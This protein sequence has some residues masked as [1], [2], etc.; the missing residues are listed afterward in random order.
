MSD[1]NSEV[2]YCI[3]SSTI[4]DLYKENGFYSKDVHITLWETIEKYISSERIISSVEVYEELKKDTDKDFIDWLRNNKKMFVEVD[5]CQIAKLKDVLNKY[6]LL[7]EGYKDR[8]DSILVSLSKCKSLALLT[9]EKSATTA[10]PNIP[11]IPNLCKE[12]GV[13]CVSVN[14]FCRKEKIVI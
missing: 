6:P 10:S 11:K 14:E 13:G 4:L 1:T 7:A 9:S 8:A 2:K 12:F 5:E 3:D